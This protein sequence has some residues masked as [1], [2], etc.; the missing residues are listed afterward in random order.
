V[1]SRRM[2]RWGPDDKTLLVQDGGAGVPSGLRVVE[3]ERVALPDTAVG[4]GSVG[5]GYRPHVPLGTRGLWTVEHC[6]EE[7]RSGDQGNKHED[8]N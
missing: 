5:P 6:P 1:P 7:D 8:L 4:D 3:A 2:R